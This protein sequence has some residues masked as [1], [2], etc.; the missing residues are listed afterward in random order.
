MKNTGFLDIE[1]KPILLGNEVEV[2][3]MGHR[4]GFGE[5]VEVDNVPCVNHLGENI[6]YM[7]MNLDYLVHIKAIKVIN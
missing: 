2:Y 5:I 1:N 3:S 6:E 4:I 7:I